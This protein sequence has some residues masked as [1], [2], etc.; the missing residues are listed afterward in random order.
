[1]KLVYISPTAVGSFSDGVFKAFD[2][3]PSHYIKQA[4]NLWLSSLYHTM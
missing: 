4:Y 1:M 2:D 3:I